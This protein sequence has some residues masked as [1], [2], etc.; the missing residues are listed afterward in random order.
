M[1]KTK[2]KIS[3]VMQRSMDDLLKKLNAP[4]AFVALAITIYL[5]GK[6]MRTSADDREQIR[7]LSLDWLKRLEERKDENKR[8]PGY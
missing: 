4:D 3:N 7:A 1:P 2:A 6:G 5:Q 8:F